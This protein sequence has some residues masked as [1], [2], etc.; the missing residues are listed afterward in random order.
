MEPGDYA[1]VFIPLVAPNPEA[2]TGGNSS[3]DERGS[4]LAL[5]KTDQAQQFF[6]GGL[7]IDADRAT[8][9]KST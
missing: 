2:K 4:H 1:V 5:V 7:V 3:N 8:S 9:D 6:D